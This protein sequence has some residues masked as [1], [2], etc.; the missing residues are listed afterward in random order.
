M[1]VEGDIVALALFCEPSV[2]TVRCALLDDLDR[3]DVVLRADV[4]AVR[5]K[6]GDEIDSGL[7]M[8]ENAS[9]ARSGMPGAA[10]L[11]ST[12]I[13]HWRQVLESLV[14]L[15]LRV[16]QHGD[17]TKLGL[18]AVMS[19]STPAEVL[20]KAE[21]VDLSELVRGI[22]AGAPFVSMAN[23]DLGKTQKEGFASLEG[24]I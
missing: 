12:T 20:G 1:H 5:K 2:S 18:E 24:A 22:D 6:F 9:G 19:P 23:A 21:K 17:E 14:R 15:E 11:M 16:G 8:L 4:P 13:D 10:E 3:D 7:D